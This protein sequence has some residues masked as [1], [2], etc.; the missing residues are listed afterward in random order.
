MKTVAISN[1]G[2]ITLPAEIRRAANLLPGMRVQV[3]MRDHEIVLHPVKSLR[4]LAGVFAGR[5]AETHESFESIR[6]ITES[7]IAV[8]VAN[9]DHCGLC[10]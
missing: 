5:I 9:E 6:S 3:E 1:K 4:E 8:E 10:A 7:T 2:Q